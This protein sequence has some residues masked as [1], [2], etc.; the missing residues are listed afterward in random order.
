MDRLPGSLKRLAIR[1]KSRVGI[2]V[3]IPNFVVDMYKASQEAERSIGVI[4][5]DYLAASFTYPE[6][7]VAFRQDPKGTKEILLFIHRFL[8]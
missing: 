7:A 8:V 5:P 4:S 6:W 1:Q 3:R 2:S